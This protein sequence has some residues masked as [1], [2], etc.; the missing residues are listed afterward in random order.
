MNDIVD[1]LIY[2]SGLIADGCWDEL[3]TY[4]KEAIE[5]CILMTVE[6]C[7][8]IIKNWKVEPFPFNE[9]LAIDLIKEHFDIDKTK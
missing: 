5:R 6:E 2:K 4:A 7:C 8:E 1:K 3:D 9:D